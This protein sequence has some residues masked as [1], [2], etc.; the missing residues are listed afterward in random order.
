MNTVLNH[1]NQAL[2]RVGK[3]CV[4]N[5]N[6]NIIGIFKEIDDKFNSI[7]TK[8]FLTINNLN[9][10]DMIKYNNMNYLVITKSE[11]INGV[12]NIYT[13]RKCP[14]NINFS[15]NTSMNIVTGYIETKTLDTQASQYII[16]PTGTIVVTV[17]L[18]SITEQI[19]INNRFIKM[20]AAWKVTGRDKSLEGL[21]KITA[22]NV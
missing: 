17:P 15:I 4:L 22:E 5:N 7:D 9:Q 2:K 14:Y 6:S 19:K 18:D 10:G 16:L 3:T 20:G 13:V 21:I 1:F 12:Y 8:Y 11:N